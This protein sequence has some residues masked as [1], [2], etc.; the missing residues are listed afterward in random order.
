[1][2]HR[3]EAGTLKQFFFQILVL[4]LVILTQMA[5]RSRANRE[6]DNI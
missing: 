4:G 1:M 5:F 2:K 3:E 6:G